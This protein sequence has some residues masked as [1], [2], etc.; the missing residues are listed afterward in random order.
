MRLERCG[1]EA[2][3]TGRAAPL[4]ADSIA[5]SHSV[6][7][8]GDILCVRAHTGRLLRLMPAATEVRR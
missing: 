4:D 3:Y 8:H 7:S 5:A 6:V 1:S 2:S